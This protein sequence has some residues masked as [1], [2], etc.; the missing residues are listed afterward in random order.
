MPPRRRM[1]KRG[2]KKAR[3]YYAASNLA[4]MKRPSRNL[5][6]EIQ[7]VIAGTQETKFV[8]DYPYN[9]QTS[10]DLY[11][12]T[13]F[14]SGITST[15][16]LYALIPRVNVGSDDHQRIGNR[17][18]TSRLT[19]RM[20]MHYR[21]TSTGEDMAA[22]W[23][24]IVVFTYRCTPI[25]GPGLLDFYIQNDPTVPGVT[26]QESI[27][28]PFES[29]NIKVVKSWLVRLDNLNA[30]GAQ[31]YGPNTARHLEFSIPWKK[32]MYW[33]SGGT[34]LASTRNEPYVLVHVMNATMNGSLIGQ[35]FRIHITSKMSFTDI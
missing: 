6:T 2:A 7:K 24:R 33:E 31:N 14:S 4:R 3:S 30:P 16:E 34:D 23:A 19:V 20:V 11:A 13:N 17:I 12:A 18:E 1:I 15:N 27:T 21:S 8:V 35:T 10:S 32:N 22:I 26:I 29:T 9:S 28:A 25:S 5:K